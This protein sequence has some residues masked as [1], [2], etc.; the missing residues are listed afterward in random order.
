MTKVLLAAAGLALSTNAALVAVL[1]AVLVG[2]SD[3]AR[4]E[5]E[6]CSK[7]Y[8]SDW[9]RELCSDVRTKT[10]RQSDIESY[11]KTQCSFLKIGHE[12]ALRDPSF[13]RSSKVIA[14]A[15]RALQE[16]IDQYPGLWDTLPPAPT[17]AAATPTSYTRG[18]D[19]LEQGDFD[20]AIAEFTAAIADDP[21]NLFS[22]IRGGTAYEKKGDAASAIGDYRKVLKL[23]DAD[24]GAEYAAKIRKLE[25]TK[26]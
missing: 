19:A 14:D 1:I 13:P 25:R 26:K 12:N 18:L 15:E 9:L 7:L 5:D 23:V 8:K 17:P 24:T 20:R 4:A 16:C 6:D 21:K 2:F 22:Y 11:V 10:K 3:T